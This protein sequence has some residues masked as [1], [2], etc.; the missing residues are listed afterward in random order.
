[1][2]PKSRLWQMQGLDLV[3]RKV[4]VQILKEI[5]DPLNDN[6]TLRPTMSLI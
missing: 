6:W 2:L 5:H 4:P 1:M 3:C